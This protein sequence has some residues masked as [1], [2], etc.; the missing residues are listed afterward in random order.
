MNLETIY[1]R[2]VA[3]CQKMN[4]QVTVKLLQQLHFFILTSSK[5]E[6]SGKKYKEI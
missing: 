5:N 6:H 2:Q 1:L 4:A 3:I